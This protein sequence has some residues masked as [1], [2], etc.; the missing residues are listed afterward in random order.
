MTHRA[1]INDRHGLSR[2]GVCVTLFS[3][4]VLTAIVIPVVQCARESAR[5][6]GCANNLKS[7]GL[8]LVSYESAHGTYPKGC[9]GNAELTPSER[10]SWYLSI[11]NY[12]GHYG[13]PIIDYDRPW[14]DP[15]LRPLQLHT[16]RNGPD[17]VKEFD[18]PLFPIPVVKCPN[19]TPEIHDD[20]QPY[21]DY[22]GT[23]G[24]GPRAALLSRAD[25]RAGVWAYDE[26][27]SV[28]DIKD[29]AS[30]TLIAIETSANNGC[31]IADG[32]PTLRE[33]DPARGAI[34]RGKQFGGLHYGGS[35]AVFVDGSV[36]FLSQSVSPD[37]MSSAMT[38]AETEVNLE[39][40]PSVR[41]S[42]DNN[43][44]DPSRISGRF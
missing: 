32:K 24:I 8:T 29:G 12:W 3:L 36:D 39:Q 25:A 34:G 40:T 4:A 20:G 15:A 7:L 14:N 33:Y 16:W 44:M 41:Q 26:C 17:V 2:V 42:P 27:R 28:D 10:W 21:T 31:W 5:R 9:V 37:V 43:A 35:M 19:G 30:T 11:G 13:F 1:N 6:N 38:I 23:T 18:V 22:V